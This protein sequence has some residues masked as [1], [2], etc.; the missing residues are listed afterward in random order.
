M[1]IMLIIERNPVIDL[2]TNELVEIATSVGTPV[3]AFLMQ[4]DVA[5]FIPD[6]V[7]VPTSEP[8]GTGV[9]ATT[10]VSTTVLLLGAVAAFVLA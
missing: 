8:F 9:G 4:A 7:E 10:L 6:G 5:T 3:N 1:I 2:D